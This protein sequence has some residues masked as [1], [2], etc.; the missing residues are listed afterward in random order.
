MTRV[1]CKLYF[2]Q[3]NHVSLLDVFLQYLGRIVLLSWTSEDFAVEFFFG[4]CIS[5]CVRLILLVVCER[6]NFDMTSFVCFCQLLSRLVVAFRTINKFYAYRF[7]NQRVDG[8][9]TTLDFLLQIGRLLLQLLVLNLRNRIPL[10]LR[11]YPSCLPGTF[12]REVMSFHFKHPQK[13][14]VLILV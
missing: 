12:R 7:G 10:H 1:K 14:F 8:R 5:F 13:I 11:R 2:L 6:P 4:H 3:L 9:F